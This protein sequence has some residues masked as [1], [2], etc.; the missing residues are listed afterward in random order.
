MCVHGG[1][2]NTSSFTLR[3]KVL[4]VDQATPCGEF[5]KWLKMY[6]GQTY[7]GVLIDGSHCK[8]VHHWWLECSCLKKSSTGRTNSEQHRNSI[9]KI[10]REFKMTKSFLSRTLYQQLIRP[11]HYQRIHDLQTPDHGT[12]PI[13]SVVLEKSINT[14]STYKKN[15]IYQW[16]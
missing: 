2:N 7:F 11:F 12:S 13:L 4:E 5:V 6:F 15:N 9:H 14:Q 10:S 3:D 8:Q 1:N 16:S